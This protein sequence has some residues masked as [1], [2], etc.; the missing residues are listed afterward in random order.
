MLKL[1]SP[2]IGCCAGEH[3]TLLSDSILIGNMAG[4]K[5]KT[6]HHLIVVGEDEAEDLD[7]ECY[8]LR[9]KTESSNITK[10]ISTSEYDMIRTLLLNYGVADSFHINGNDVL[11]EFINKKQ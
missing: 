5:L 4:A 2:Y 11:A 3:G 6:G 1:Q 8:I 9:I 7:G 10:R